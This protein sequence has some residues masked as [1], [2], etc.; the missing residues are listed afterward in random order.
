MPSPTPGPPP[1]VVAAVFARSNVAI[2]LSASS[3]HSSPAVS[4]LPSVLLPRLL[5]LPLPLPLRLWLH[6][7]AAK[8]LKS[9]AGPAAAVP[10]RLAD[11]VGSAWD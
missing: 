10:L 8:S 3:V 5:P 2:V 7:F 9:L 4:W 6:R 11:R 1:A